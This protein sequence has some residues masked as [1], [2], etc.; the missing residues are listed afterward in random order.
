VDPTGSP[1]LSR[2]E[3]PGSGGPLVSYAA[4]KLGFLGDF[5]WAVLCTLQ[6]VQPPLQ[7]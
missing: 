5:V 7:T 6:H 3:G 2:G 1:V 4:H